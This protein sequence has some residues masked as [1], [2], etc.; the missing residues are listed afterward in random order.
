MN[1]ADLSGWV[2]VSG[3]LV[4]FEGGR[5]T[6]I[7]DEGKRDLEGDVRRAELAVVTGEIY[8]LTEQRVRVGEWS[9]GDSDESDAT[10]PLLEVRA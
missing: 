2:D 1:R 9:I 5:A 3:W 7:S 6:R 4:L 8:T 10:A